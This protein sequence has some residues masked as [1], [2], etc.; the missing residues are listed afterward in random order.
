MGREEDRQAHNWPWA[1]ARLF[2]G[3]GAADLDAIATR[4]SLRPFAAGDVL[5]R[6][7]A[8]SGQ[9][10]ILRTGIVQISVVAESARGEPERTV[11]LRRLVSGECFGEM[12][13]ITGD[14]PSATV[15][16][17]TEGEAWILSQQD[18]LQLAMA[19]P[20]FSLNI[21]GIL[22]ER[23]SHTSRQQVAEAPPQVEPTSEP[24]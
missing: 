17:L 24:E 11:P 21:N 20:R 23:L 18:F 6:Q 3:L 2:Q 12:S 22:S 4:L 9:L 13:L 1:R 8:W 7:G 15:Q 19:H 14:A 5:I 10:Y 16:A